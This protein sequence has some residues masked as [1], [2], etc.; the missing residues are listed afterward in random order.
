MHLEDI[1]N[2]TIQEFLHLKSP[3]RTKKLDK[4]F[5]PQQQSEFYKLQP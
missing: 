5:S 1:H 4:M 3:A 2:I